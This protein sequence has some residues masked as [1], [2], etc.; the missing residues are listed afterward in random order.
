MELHEYYVKE[1]FRKTGL[2]VSDGG[3]AYT[4]KEAQ[5]VAKRIG[6]GPFW[7][8]PQILLGYAHNKKEDPLLEKKTAETPEQVF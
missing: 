8:K 3:V 6:K 5:N 2:P 7:I 4:P 1:I